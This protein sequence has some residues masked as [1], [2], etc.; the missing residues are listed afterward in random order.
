MTK[1]K[2][3]PWTVERLKACGDI[4]RSQLGKRYGDAAT[5]AAKRLGV[6]DTMFPSQGRR[7]REYTVERIWVIARSC[8]SRSEF[9]YK[10]SAVAW[11]I[12]DGFYESI[13]QYLWFKENETSALQYNTRTEF[14]KGDPTRYNRSITLKHINHFNLV[15]DRKDHYKR[16]D[17]ETFTVEEV[18]AVAAKYTSKVTFLRDARPYYMAMK[19]LDC[20][21][22]HFNKC[23]LDSVVKYSV[24][25]DNPEAIVEEALKYDTWHDFRVGSC[26]AYKYSKEYE[27]FNEIDI[28]M[29]PT[30]NGSDF[31]T[32]Y[33]WEAVGHYGLDGSKIY[34]IGITS[35]RLGH[36]R[37][38]SVSS[39]ASINAKIIR[40][41]KTDNAL[42]IEKKL[43]RYGENA[44]FKGFGG[45]SEFRI[46]KWYH[47]E[48]MLDELDTMTNM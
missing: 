41:I 21:P 20:E 7:E 19:Y 31:N 45:F 18:H 38:K 40:L 24:F 15:D 23:F 28:F 43:L 39:Q 26:S 4:S 35:W 13:K 22:P 1:H 12:K 11:A 37:I 32:I 8:A 33:I 16:P 6:Y 34:K 29:L 2:R 10:H 27:L 36:N 14:K 42:E 25:K 47:F 30:P 17:W 48:N 46:I 3:R 5:R 9:A 44:G